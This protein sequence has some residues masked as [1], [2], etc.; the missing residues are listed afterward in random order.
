MFGGLAIGLMFW[1][2]IFAGLFVL[3]NGG[4][5]LI[6]EMGVRP[7]PRGHGFDTC[8][9]LSFID[10]LSHYKVFSVRVNIAVYSSL[11]KIDA[12]SLTTLTG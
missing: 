8:I 11:E 10:N 2:N 1:Q 7:W 6:I 12:Q 3:F 9:H 4:W 5:F